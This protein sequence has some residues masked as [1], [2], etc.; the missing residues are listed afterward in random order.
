MWALEA[1]LPAPDPPWSLKPS[2]LTFCGIYKI[3]FRILFSEKTPKGNKWPEIH[4][5]ISGE[6][7]MGRRDPLSKNSEI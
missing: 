6:A 3:E 5:N 2:L 4:M 7:V 1:H